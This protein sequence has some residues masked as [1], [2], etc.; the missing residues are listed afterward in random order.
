MKIPIPYVLGLVLL[1]ACK[2]GAKPNQAESQKDEI[3]VEQSALEDMQLPKDPRLAIHE[4]FKWYEDNF[5]MVR[6]AQNAIIDTTLLPDGTFEKISVNYSK[7]DQYI[8]VLLSSGRISNAYVSDFKEYVKE[9]EEAAQY[10]GDYSYL[11]LDYDMI[12]NPYTDND[13][14]VFRKI[15]AAPLSYKTVE[16]GNAVIGIQLSADNKPSFNLSLVNGKWL[17]DKAHPDR[18]AE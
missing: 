1:F 17:I 15:S 3:K 6:S 9:M 11:S 14:S 7:L 10:E 8:K 16:N 18:S 12:L 4:F 13:K 2:D 5:E